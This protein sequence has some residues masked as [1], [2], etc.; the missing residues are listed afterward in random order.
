MQATLLPH[1]CIILNLHRQW[2]DDDSS[3][4]LLSVFKGNCTVLGNAKCLNPNVRQKLSS[5]CVFPLKQTGCVAMSGAKFGVSCFKT[6]AGG[7]NTPQPQ[8]RHMEMSVESCQIGDPG[9]A[10]ESPF[11]APNRSYPRHPAVS[12]PTLVTFR[13]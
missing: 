8:S 5:N 10:Y 1:G 3:F 9:V 13:S 4:S 11:N 6:Q 7:S 2:G 12:P